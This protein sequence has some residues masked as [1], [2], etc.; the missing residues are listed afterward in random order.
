[1]FVLCRKKQITIT[2]WFIRKPD[3]LGWHLPSYVFSYYGLAFYQLQQPLSL[4]GVLKEYHA[5]IALG[6]NS[7]TS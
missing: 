6:K 7:R 2:E 1:M 4:A 5:K 3:S